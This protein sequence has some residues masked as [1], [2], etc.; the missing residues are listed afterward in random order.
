MSRAFSQADA[1]MPSLGVIYRTFESEAQQ[2]RRPTHLAARIFRRALLLV[3]MAALAV[4]LWLGAVLIQPQAAQ[5]PSA[6]T[7]EE[8]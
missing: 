2:T 8:Q 4:A 3:L 5:E 6:M 1:G 7:V